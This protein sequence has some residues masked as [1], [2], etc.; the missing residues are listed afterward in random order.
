MVASSTKRSETSVPRM[1]PSAAR[2]ARASVAHRLD[3]HRWSR[4]LVGGERPQTVTL[5]DSPSLSASRLL[6]GGDDVCHDAVAHHVPMRRD[7]RTPGPSMPPRISSRPTS[8]ERPPGRSIWVTSP[9]T[10]ALEPKP[11]R[12]RNIFIC[13]GVVFCASSRMMKLLL[14]VR[15][16]MKASGATSIGAPFEQPLGAFGLEHVVEGVVERAQVGV[17]LGHQVAGQ[18]AEPFAGLDRGPGQD[19]A[20]DLL[21]LQGLHGERHR[22]IG[23]AGAGGADPEGDDVGGDGV[24]VALLPAGLRADRAARET[25]AAPRR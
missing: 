12:V 1:I 8:P 7:G 3:R 18:E 23:L 14:S 22:Q 10:T 9:V 20:V 4:L 25:S 17:D 11:M 2:T 16:R 6:V 15:P 13:S 5:L 21:G 19:D 24:D